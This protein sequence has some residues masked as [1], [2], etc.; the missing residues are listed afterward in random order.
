MQ[1]KKCYR[2]K[3]ITA[4]FCS[5]ILYGLLAFNVSKVGE[6]A[7]QTLLK[8]NAVYHVQDAE[9]KLKKYELL[10]S[11]DG[12][13]RYRRHLINGQQQYCSFNLTRF[14][15]LDYIGSTDIG[16]LI[17]RTQGEDVIVQTYNDPN[18]NVDSMAFQ[19]QFPV[20]NLEAEDLHFIREN[21][22]QIKRELQPR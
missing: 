15:D 11:N 10:I 7:R 20:K 6:L 14:K 9:S 17:L 2:H 1:L 16:T 18:G 12:F 21:L 13:I 8:M 4:I 5:A 3:V 19:V 22:L